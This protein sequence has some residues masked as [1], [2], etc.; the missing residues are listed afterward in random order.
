MKTYMLYTNT[1]GELFVDGVNVHEAK[2]KY[3]REAGYGSYSE[4]LMHTNE[5][6]Q[7]LA[8]L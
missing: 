8:T 7:T 4:M 1:Y 2:D 6:I 3:A 5:D